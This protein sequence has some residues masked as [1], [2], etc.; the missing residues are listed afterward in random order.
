MTVL[1]LDSDPATVR[2]VRAVVERA[3]HES[4][5][6]TIMREMDGYVSE[7]ITALRESVNVLAERLAEVLDALEAAK[8]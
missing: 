3:M 4:V 7:E 8:P 6:R 5:E 2:E 1:S